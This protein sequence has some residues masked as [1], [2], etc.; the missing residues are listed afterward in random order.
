MNKLE[1]IGRKWFE[2]MWNKP[3]FDLANEIVDSEYN[4][5]WIHIDKVGPSQIQ[6]EIKH[7]RS[8]FP[9]LKYQILEMVIEKNTVWIRYQAQATHKGSGWGFQ[10]TNKKVQF[11]GATILYIN[12]E[13]KV[14]DQ[15]GAF[16]FYDIFEVLGVVPP[17]H[18]LHKYLF[19]FNSSLE[20]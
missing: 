5:S 15:W 10:P 16:C 1:E 9:D 13:G 11:E 17:F 19:D 8:I 2:I 12:S 14:Y 7:F 3:D 6:H 20:K 18:E 4:P